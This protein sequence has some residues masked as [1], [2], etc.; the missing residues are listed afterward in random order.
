MFISFLLFNFE[1]VKIRKPLFT[2]SEREI[3]FRNAFEAIEAAVRAAPIPFAQEL[4]NL[5][6]NPSGAFVTIYKFG[7]LRGCVGEVEPKKPLLQAVID[8]AYNSAINDPRFNPLTQDELEDIQ[9]EISIIS[10]LKEIENINEIEVG[11]HGILMQQGEKKGLLLPQV[12]TEYNWD[13]ETFLNQTARKAGLQY[14]A[15]KKGNVK[16]SIFTAEIINQP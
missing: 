2:K 5:L 8:A 4:T 3:L 10:N 6:N 14:D 16:I 12:A 15:W 13:R 11:V 9:L 1:L 7:E